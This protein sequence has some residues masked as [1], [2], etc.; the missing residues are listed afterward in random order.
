M[1]DLLEYADIRNALVSQTGQVE[2]IPR[3]YREIGKIKHYYPKPC[4]VL[5]E[6]FDG[7][8][9]KVGDSVGFL[10]EDQRFEQTVRSLEIDRK[11][12]EVVCSSIEFGILVEQPVDKTFRLFRIED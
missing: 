7:Q 3:N 12:V 6:L 9:L 5:V 2:Y 11:P 8:E 10:S 1:K 4:A